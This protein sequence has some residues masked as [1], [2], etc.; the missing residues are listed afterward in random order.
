LR[1]S[2]RGTN[3]HENESDYGM[4]ELCRESSGFHRRTS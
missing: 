3:A 1:Q 2:T 4:L